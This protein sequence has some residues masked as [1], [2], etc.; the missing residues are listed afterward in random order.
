M[1]VGTPVR[2]S[3][4][5]A[6]VGVSQ[7]LHESKE[8]RGVRPGSRSAA[9]ADPEARERR[10]ARRRPRWRREASLLLSD[11]GLACRLALGRSY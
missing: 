5:R 1:G 11:L 10:G 6:G 2:G 4:V 8:G 3:G 9:G 7:S